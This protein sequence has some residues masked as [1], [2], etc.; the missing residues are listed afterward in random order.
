MSTIKRDLSFRFSTW[1]QVNYFTIR[2]IG[3]QE[4]RNYLVA[5]RLVLSDP[6]I[7]TMAG[8]EIECSNNNAYNDG[9]GRQPWQPAYITARDLRITVLREKYQY[10]QGRNDKTYTISL[11]SSVHIPTLINYVSLEILFY[12]HYKRSSRV[13]HTYW[14]IRWWFVKGACESCPAYLFM[15]Q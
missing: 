11:I 4:L 5:Q 12:N 13:L 10:A 8:R 7:L 9:A 3:L 6:T 14:F 2:F 15:V 1:N